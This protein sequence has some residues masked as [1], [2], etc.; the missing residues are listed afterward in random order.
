MHSKSN[1][2]ILLI[3]LLSLVMA[4]AAVICVSAASVSNACAKID[5]SN[6]ILRKSASTSSKVLDILQDNTKLTVKKVVFTSKSSTAKKN[7]WFYV[8]A[9][10]KTGYVRSDLV[11]TLKYKATDGKTTAK[12]DYRKGAGTSMDVVGTYKKGKSIDLVLKAKAKT[13]DTVWYQVKEGSKY[14]FVSGEYVSLKEEYKQESKEPSK[15]ETKPAEEEK[16][17]E[18]D[19]TF[20]KTDITYP[21]DLNMGSSFSIKGEVTCDKTIEKVRFGILD[22]NGDWVEYV[23]KKVNAKS[24]SISKVDNDVHFGRLWDGEY[25]YNGRFYVD[26]KWYKS[27]IKYSFTV[28]GPKRTLTDK[29]VKERIQEIHEALEGTYFTT[30]GKACFVNDAEACNVCKV[31][32]QNKT[33]K[34]LIKEH[35][36]EGTV[37]TALFPHHYNPDGI[38]MTLG[39]SCCGFAGF[40]G[41]YVGADD[42]N[43]NVEY[44]I[45]KCGCNFNYDTF[46]KYARV[47][48]LIRTKTHSFMVVSVKESGC[49]VIDSNWGYTCKYN[50]HDIPWTMYDKVTISR[51]TNRK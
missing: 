43:S 11:D 27:V 16:P 24:F 29:I 2:R 10:S 28:S 5:G 40:A 47:G 46:K 26:G 20:T 48:D 41:W 3:C 50:M 8:T 36:G 9:G 44:M 13:D 25:K 33:V 22:S 21:K 14:Y 39:W 32:T 42:I 49:E 34:N 35:K 17:K 15:E 37:N 19:V 12:L 7:K 31:I 30:N 23:D 45:A 1:K 38:I 6:V 4:M 51:A 18:D